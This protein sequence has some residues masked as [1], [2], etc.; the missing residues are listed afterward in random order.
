M[1]KDKRIAKEL[2]RLEALFINLDENHKE[3]A[4]GLIRSAA[5]IAVSLEDLEEIINTNGYLDEYENGANQSGVKISAAV[6][7]Y[8][9]M[10]GRYTTIIKNLLKIVPTKKEPIKAYTEPAKIKSWVPCEQ[11]YEEYLAELEA[12]KDE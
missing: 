3:T 2:E 10:V 11:T 8:N 7:T 4:S 1:D 9:S 6:Q 5:F 12:S